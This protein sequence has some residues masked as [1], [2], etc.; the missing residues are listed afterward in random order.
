MLRYIQ[1]FGGRTHPQLLGAKNVATFLAH[2]ATD[3][4]GT[5]S[6]QRQALNALVFLYKHVLDIPLEEEI[7]PTRS[8][9]V[10]HPPTVMFRI[11]W[12][13]NIPTQQGLT[14]GNGF[15]RQK[16]DR[17]IHA[18]AGKCALKETQARSALFNFNL[19]SRCLSPLDDLA[20]CRIARF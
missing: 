6:T 17:P 15:F 8:R 11:L 16:Q 7:A 3:G 14:A 2:L 13:R 5:S 9:K 4:Q 1:Y 12:L 18:P 20:S 10:I 19:P